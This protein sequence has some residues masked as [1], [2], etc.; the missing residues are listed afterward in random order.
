M[1][2]QDSIFSVVTEQEDRVGGV[3]LYLRNDLTGEVLGSMDNG[4]CE[5]LVVHIHQLNTVVAVTYR[6]PDTKLAEFTPIL[7]QVDKLLC[8]LSDPVP[9]IIFLGDFNFQDQNLSWVRSEDGLLVP[10]VHSLRFKVY[11][12]LHMNSINKLIYEFFFLRNAS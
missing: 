8:D 4:V 9:N 1:I 7:S 5:I 2:F 3:A 6:P 10:L 12:F 11:I